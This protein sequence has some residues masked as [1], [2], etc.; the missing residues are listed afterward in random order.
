VKFCSDC[1]SGRLAFRIPEGDNL[2]RHVCDDCGSIHYQNPR[3]IAGCI[4]QWEGRVLLCRRAIEPRYGLWTLPAG[5]ME[6]GESTPAAAA[7]EALEE[8]NAQ[9]D[10]L[11]L[12]GVY[13]LPY[14]NQVYMIFR[15]LLR[16]GIASAGHETLE[17]AFF[18]R[19]STPWDR[20][21]F[22]V[23]RDS[24]QQYFREYEEGAFRVHTV[25]VRRSADGGI[26]LQRY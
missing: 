5:F 21:A 11:S 16:D 23:V 8:A 19:T 26:Q 14:I 2:P 12:Y 13:S 4:P 10:D 20:L 17:V 1:G 18:D 7:R 22:T 25:D 6:N 9:L 3:I 15:G 24:L